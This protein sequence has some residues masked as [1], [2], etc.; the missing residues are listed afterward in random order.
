MEMY[1]G[2]G[3]FWC[4]YGTWMWMHIL[5]WFCFSSLMQCDMTHYLNFWE[6]TWVYLVATQ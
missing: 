2:V 3:G 6:V 1:V 4:K 5:F